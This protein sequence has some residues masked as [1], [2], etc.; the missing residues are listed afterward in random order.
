MIHVKH[1]RFHRQGAMATKVVSDKNNTS[2]L[3][4]VCI[5]LFDSLDT[6]CH[7]KLWIKTIYFSL[8]NKVNIATV[9]YTET[10]KILP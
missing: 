2:V 5:I 6:L 9:L 8:R 3:E 1:R 4:S 10:N 7:V